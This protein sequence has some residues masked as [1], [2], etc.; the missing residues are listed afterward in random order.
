[1]TFSSVVTPNARVNHLEL[2]CATRLFLK[3]IVPEYNAQSIL[4]ESFKKSIKNCLVDAALL[5]LYPEVHAELTSYVGVSL[6]FFV[7]F[8]YYDKN[9]F[10]IM[11][12][13]KL[14]KVAI[15]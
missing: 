1:M 6:N 11:K 12:S 15:S 7:T 5:Q 2:L 3:S 13:K 10:G 8:V 9:L 4:P 14:L